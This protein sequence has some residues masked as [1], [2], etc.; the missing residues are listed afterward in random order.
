MSD[1]ELLKKEL[2]GADSNGISDIKFWPGNRSK[3]SPEDFAR[4]IRMALK[5]SKD[6]NTTPVSLD[7]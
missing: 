5:D 6:G 1:L 4:G 7:Y 3:T 2:F